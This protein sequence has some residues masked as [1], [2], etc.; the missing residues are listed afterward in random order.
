MLERLFPA[1]NIQRTR[2]GSPYVIEALAQ[3]TSSTAN[4][5]VGF[6]ANG[7]VLLASDMKHLTKLPTRDAVLPILAVL[8]LS[9]PNG[10]AQRTK[11]LPQRYTASDR[12]QN[13]DPAHSQQWLEH[14]QQNPASLLSTLYPDTTVSVQS[15][16]TRDGL[17]LTLNNQDIIHLRASGNA[18]ELRCYAES[19][20]CH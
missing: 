10:I 16:D 11:T 9:Q 13:I 8:A 15:T 5:V 7:G 3:F 6:E 20:T 4:T 1:A 12:L 17:R 2:I 14:V 19:H 18:N